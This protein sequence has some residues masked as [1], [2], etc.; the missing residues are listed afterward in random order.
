[1]RGLELERAFLTCR[2]DAKTELVFFVNAGDPCPEVTFDMLRVLDKHRVATVELCVPFPKSLTDGSL[3]K[4]SHQRALS[5]GSTLSTVLE[6]VTRARRELG[7]KIVLLADYGYTVK[8]L[9]LERFLQAC[10]SAGTHATLIHCLPQARRH[11]YVEQSAKLGLGRIMSFFVGSEER[12]RRAA[13]QEAEGFIYVVSRFGRTGQK[14][15]FDAVLL[16]Q[17]G[18]IRAETEKPL[19]VGFGVK[20]A[21]DIS[22]LRGTGAD[23]LIIGSAATALVQNNIATPERIAASFDDLVLRFAGAASPS[24]HPIK[25]KSVA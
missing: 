22:T 8:P 17:L 4:A 12:V 14:V 2:R 10:F 11:D 16:D 15:S 7:L 1:M 24:S 19:A 18:N 23:A 9:G 5:N 21:E 3:I 20:T 25:T 13:Y 6:L